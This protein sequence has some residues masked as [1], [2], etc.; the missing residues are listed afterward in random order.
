MENRLPRRK[1]RK[2]V[3]EMQIDEMDNMSGVFA[4]SLVSDP[5][6]EENWVY[7]SKQ[8][9]TNLAQISADK[10]LLLG[11]VLVP[12]KLIPRIDEETGE[13]YD[14]TFTP[15]TIE[16]AAHLYMQRQMNNNATLEHTTDVQD[17]STVESW[18]IVDSENDKSVKFGMSYPKGTWMA[19]MKVNNPEIWND[20]V[21]TGKIKGFSIEGMLGHELVKASKI[22]GLS[23]QELDAQD[24]EAFAA[25]ILVEM[26]KM[27]EVELGYNTTGYDQQTQTRGLAVPPPTYGRTSYPVQPAPAGLPPNWGAPSSGDIYGNLSNYDGIALESYSDYPD[28]VRN[29]AKRALEFAEEN[30]WGSCGTP[31]GKIRANQLADGKPISVDTI[32]RMYSY[33]KRHE[34]DLES[35]TSYNDGCG[36]LMFDSWGGKAA[37]RWSASKLKEL[38]LLDNLA[39]AEFETSVSVGSSYAGQFGNPKKRK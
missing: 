8:K 29:N 20:F 39:W 15:E 7:M 19:M 13:E 22:Q 12:H 33:L 32:K 1:S 2:K 30:G 9:P 26:K 14:I 24:D 11:P 27:L 28:G 25:E 38:G 37:M 18:I 23:M 16:K 21:K 34:V 17:V 35:S 5:A 4:I 10:R 36:K 31:V 3:Y 6:I